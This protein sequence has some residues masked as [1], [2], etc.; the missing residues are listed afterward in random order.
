MG[1]DYGLETKNGDGIDFDVF[2]AALSYL[3]EQVGAYGDKSIVCQLEKILNIDLRLFQNTYN[4]EMDFEE[5]FDTDDLWVTI[6]VVINKLLEFNSKAEANKN[7][8]S[9]LILN[10]NKNGTFDES[11]PMFYYPLE[12]EFIS[13]NIINNSIT[14]LLTY[15]ENL[16]N[17]GETEI[18]LVYA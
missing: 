14:E 2:P 12:N 16:K 10:P 4:P 18:R 6:D 5:E 13:E 11:N 1:M 9:K 15:L 8:Y 17:K 3:F 7:Y